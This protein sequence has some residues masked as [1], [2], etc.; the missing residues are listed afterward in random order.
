MVRLKA[1]V[2]SLRY[3]CK[4][5]AAAV[6]AG[7]MSKRS[8]DACIYIPAVTISKHYIA[9]E[10]LVCDLCTVEAMLCTTTCML[11]SSASEL[12]EEL[13]TCTFSMSV[14]SSTGHDLMPSQQKLVLPKR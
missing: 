13:L 14:P 6:G 12:A 5:S 8:K 11:T 1:S 3:C 7:G 10:C 9:V 2:T 4:I